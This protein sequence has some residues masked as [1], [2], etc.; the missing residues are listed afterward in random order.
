MLM[1]TEKTTKQEELHKFW[2]Q[3]ASQDQW[4][5]IM[6]ECRNWFGKNWKC[7]GKVRRKL[8]PSSTLRQRP[9]LAV[10][11]EVPDSRFATWVSVKYSIQVQSDA[12]FNS[13]K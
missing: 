13:G 11:F 12:K 10:W 9:S 6:R 2:F 5:N 8:N 3:I 7:Q 4:Y 1:S